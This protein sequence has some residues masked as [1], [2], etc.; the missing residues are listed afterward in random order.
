MHGIK[1]AAQAVTDRFDTS[2]FTPPDHVEMVEPC[3]GSE[4]IDAFVLGQTQDDTGDANWSIRR[5]C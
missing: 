1:R 5:R 4:R 3:F 2:H